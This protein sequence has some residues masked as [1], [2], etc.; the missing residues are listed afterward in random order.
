MFV[1][2]FYM[3]CFLFCVF[4]VFFF[5]YFLLTY[6]VIYFL[7]VYNFTDHCHREE[8][9]LYFINFVSYH[10]LYHHIMYHVS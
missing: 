7:F 8:A 1:F 4:C 5:A 2:L 3:F 10:T 9:Q 6:L